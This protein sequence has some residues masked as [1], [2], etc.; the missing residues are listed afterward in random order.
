M[1]TCTYRSP[2]EQRRLYDIGRSVPGSI[3]TNVDGIHKKSNHNLY[4]C[5]AIDFCIVDGGKVIW[6]RD[7]YEPIGEMCQ[8]VGLV[9][10][11][12]WKSI[13]DYTHV[14]LAKAA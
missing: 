12:S 9:W 13:D 7:V 6:S 3:R 4:P 11:G 14:E 5:R 2:E 1:V 8:A 10:G